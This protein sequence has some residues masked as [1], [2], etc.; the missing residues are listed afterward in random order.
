MQLKCYMV[1]HLAA[2]ILN[3]TDKSSYVK[4]KCQSIRQ[5]SGFELWTTSYVLQ[6][7]SHQC[8]WYNEYFMFIFGYSMPV[9]I[10]LKYGVNH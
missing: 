4:T 8:I 10:N 7:G 5:M 1:W 3:K 6:T 2:V 9:Q